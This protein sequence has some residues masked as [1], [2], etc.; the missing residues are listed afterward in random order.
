MLPQQDSYEVV[1]ERLVSGTWRALILQ[2]AHWATLVLPYCV[3]GENTE[4]NVFQLFPIFAD[5]S[6]FLSVLL[7]DLISCLTKL[8]FSLFPPTTSAYFP[9]CCALVLTNQ[10]TWRTTS[11]SSADSIFLSF[12]LQAC[13]RSQQ[14]NKKLILC[15]NFAYLIYRKGTV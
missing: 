13:R 6:C 8:R 2:Q 10:A 5:S 3:I 14:E 4:Q 1:R 15:N 11:E 9:K 12:F 7:L